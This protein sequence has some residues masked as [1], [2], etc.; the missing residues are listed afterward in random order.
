V[1]GW[2]LGR[3]GIA[4]A[5]GSFGGIVAFL[6]WVYYSAQIMLFGAEFTHV[7]ARRHGS[8]SSATLDES[9]KAAPVIG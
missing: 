7:Y 5:Y 6:I 3:A 8:L 1:L 4:S 2:Y 9:S